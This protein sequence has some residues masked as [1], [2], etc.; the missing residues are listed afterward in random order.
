[1]IK[2][3]KALISIRRLSGQ[4]MLAAAV[5]SMV[6]L[7]ALSLVVNYYIRG[8]LMET[9]YQETGQRLETLERFLDDSVRDYKIDV[10]AIEGYPP[11]DGIYRAQINDGIDPIDN[12]TLDQWRSRLTVLFTNYMSTHSGV[13]QVRY[14]DATGMEWLRVD[15]AGDQPQVVPEVALQDKSD[16]AYFLHAATIEP[17]QCHVSPISLNVDHGRMQIDNPVLRVSTPVWRDDQFYGVI[18]MNISA[19]SIMKEVE[20]QVDNSKII[21]ATESGS[22]MSHPNE[23]KRWSSQ[24]GNEELLYTDWPELS[25]GR[26]RTHN[27]AESGRPLRLTSQD[28]DTDLALSY[29]KFDEINEGWIIGLELDREEVYSA[30]G[31]MTRFILGLTGLVGVIA[32][33]FALCASLIWVRPLREISAASD[34]IRKGDYKIRINSSRSDELG[35]MAQSFNCMAEELDQALESERMRAKAE[36]SNHAKS[37]FLANMSHEIRTP[38][39]AILGFTELLRDYG[40]TKL[41]SKKRIHAIDTI[42]NA[43]DHLLTLINNI[44]DL[45]KIE[46]DKMT[47]EYIDTPFIEL[48]REVE[49]LMRPIA[50][51]KGVSLNTTLVT[52]VPEHIHSDPTRLRQILM[53][54]VG[55][56]VKFTEAGSVTVSVSA[57]GSNSGTRMIID[58]E[59]TGVGMSIEQSAQ[60]FQAFGQADDTMTRKFGGSGL[61]LTICRRFATLMGGDVKVL[62]SE[63][64][65]GSCFRLVMPFESV[66]GTETVTSID[67]VNA[68]SNIAAPVI[69]TKL[70]GRILLAEDGIDNQRLIEFH[71]KKSGADVI[72]ADN[73]KIA[74]EMIDKAVADGTPY[75]LL[76]TDMQMPE[77]DGYMLAQ[78]LRERGSSLPIV[79]LTAHAMAEDRAKCIKA[80]C[81]DYATKP[82]N[83][84][85]LLKTCAEWMGKT[86][87][88]HQHIA[89]A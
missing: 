69:T 1:L 76:L 57:V 29:V 44:L 34:A 59:D 61:G 64:G 80:G 21:F 38:L 67:D 68:S 84:T 78:T 58:I 49:S 71:L 33:A 12:S 53:N 20:R 14:L 25:L 4:Y 6:P 11:I 19:K 27:L 2:K 35:E 22:Y 85:I 39:T 8:E 88:S 42:S 5:L 13:L 83:K 36:A 30:S 46:A 10:N 81:D 23:N 82:I 79:A 66:S 17:D 37:T 9:S 63:L 28:G 62:H 7:L 16:Q 72:I 89:A 45:S 40:D 50:I 18:V 73:G 47:V 60:L 54:L 26:I 70:S 52:N 51:G 15:M 75:D 32:I 56:A 74:L 24:I 65:K 86:G 55:N 43:G 3:L 31:A 48:L 41:D 77:M 87:G